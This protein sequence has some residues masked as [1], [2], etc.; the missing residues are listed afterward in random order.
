MPG[1]TLA[2]PR[3][4]MSNWDLVKEM[5]WSWPIIW[6]DEVVEADREVLLVCENGAGRVL[7]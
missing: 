1:L 4:L 6:V 2:A 5:H 3:M 7:N